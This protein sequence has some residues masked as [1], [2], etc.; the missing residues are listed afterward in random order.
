MCEIT[1]SVTPSIY[2]CHDFLLRY[3]VTSFAAAWDLI[4][5][6]IQASQLHRLRPFGKPFFIYKQSH[7]THQLLLVLSLSY[8]FAISIKY[9]PYSGWYLCISLNIEQNATLAVYYCLVLLISTR[10]N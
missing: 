4:S 10:A 8:L 5:C 9:E 3:S 1:S 2:L 7:Y 6:L